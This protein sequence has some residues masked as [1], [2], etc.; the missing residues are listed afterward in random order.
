MLRKGETAP[1]PT[2]LWETVIHPLDAMR[3]LAEEVVAYQA[4]ARHVNDVAWYVVRLSFDAGTLGTLEVLPT[5]GGLVETY[6]LFGD[7]YHAMAQLVEHAPVS[8]RCWEGA[9]LACEDEPARDQPP[10]VRNGAYDETVEFLTALREHRQPR[11][12]PTEVLPSVE[13]V[14]AIHYACRST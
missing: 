6:N 14:H 4:K 11:P 5:T 12:S 9:D 13:L 1:T 10:F 7:N 8:V 3:S 2:F